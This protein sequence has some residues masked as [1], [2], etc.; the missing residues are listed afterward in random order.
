M[1]PCK[2]AIRSWCNMGHFDRSTQS[3]SLNQSLVKILDTTRQTCVEGTQ[4]TSRCTRP[5]V[6]QAQRRS[7]ARRYPISTGSSGHRARGNL[8]P[9]SLSGLPRI[10]STASAKAPSRAG[11]TTALTPAYDC[12]AAVNLGGQVTGHGTVSSHCK[13]P[14][15]GAASPP[16]RS[17]PPW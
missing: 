14:V 2:I 3:L 8:R 11:A 15:V 5:L 9:T 4:V 1:P 10:L 12:F 7:A 17:R 16:K 13:E 6:R